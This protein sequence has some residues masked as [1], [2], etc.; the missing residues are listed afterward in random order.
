MKIFKFNEFLNESVGIPQ[1]IDDFVTLMEEQ[2]VIE[3]YPEDERDIVR[4]GW[5]TKEHKM[6]STPAIKRYFKNKYGSEYNSM[7]IDIAHQYRPNIKILTK[8]LAD[9]GMTLQTTPVKGQYGEITWF[10]SVNLSDEERNKIKAKYEA[11]FAKRYAK[12][13]D[14]KALARRPITPLKKRR[15]KGGVSEALELLIESLFNLK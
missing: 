5:I 1:I 10:Y 9:K 6:Y 12:Y 3:M 11:E 7:D 14:K 13:F 8:K 4:E 2:P 15:R